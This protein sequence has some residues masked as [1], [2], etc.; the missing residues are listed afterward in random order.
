MSFS[1]LDK[2]LNSTFWTGWH[3]FKK[4]HVIQIEIRAFTCHGLRAYGLIEKSGQGISDKKAEPDSKIW[5]LTSLKKYAWWREWSGTSIKKT[6]PKKRTKNVSDVL[7]MS[8]DPGDIVLFWPGGFPRNERGFI[9][10]IWVYHQVF[11]SF[12]WDLIVQLFLQEFHAGTG[13]NSYMRWYSGLYCLVWDRTLPH[14]DTCRR[15]TH[16]P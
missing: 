11:F 7:I 8:R 13:K 1:L 6:D 2:I 9:R 3:S 10:G 5:L 4:C 15:E 16:V 14:E 12:V